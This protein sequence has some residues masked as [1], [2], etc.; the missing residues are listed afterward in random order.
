VCDSNA[1]VIPQDQSAISGGQRGELM[2]KLC[3]LRGL[4]SRAHPVSRALPAHVGA[5]PSG[6]D[7]SYLIRCS[8]K[9]TPRSHVVDSDRCGRYRDRLMFRPQHTMKR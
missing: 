1:R 6:S 2:Q 7:P 8:P 5:S 3:Y 4:L 9:A